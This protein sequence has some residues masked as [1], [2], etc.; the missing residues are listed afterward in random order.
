[1]ATVS[2]CSKA[3]T[4]RQSET[5]APA[6]APC[7]SCTRPSWARP[8]MRCA[9]TRT[10]A[11]PI[12][13]G[14]AGAQVPQRLDAS[15][16]SA[17][18]RVRLLRASATRATCRLPGGNAAARG[19]TASSSTAASSSRPCSIVASDGV[20]HAAMAFPCCLPE[21]RPGTSPAAAAATCAAA[22]LRRASAT[23]ASEC[24]DGQRRCSGRH[25]RG[26]AGKAGK[27]AS[28]A[29]A[30]A[31]SSRPTSIQ[32]ATKTGDPRY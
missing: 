23:A 25:R 1:M 31:A 8:R 9:V 11:R 32:Q 29:S 30:R 21:A 22:R 18:G 4:A 27:R 5:A 3:C 17:R 16:R 7:S 12:R 26:E 13:R 20:V 28:R 10:R 19:N 24:R 2:C 14:R 15:A 6:G